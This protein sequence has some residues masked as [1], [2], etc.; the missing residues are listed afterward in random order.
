MLLMAYFQFLNYNKWGEKNKRR[1]LLY[2]KEREKEVIVSLAECC[3]LL[4]APKEHFQQEPAPFGS[5][6]PK[7]VFKQAAKN[8]ATY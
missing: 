5:A 8:N 3:Q 6:A 1:E 4:V 7:F 2:L